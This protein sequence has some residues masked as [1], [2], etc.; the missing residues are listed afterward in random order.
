[1]ATWIKYLQQKIEDR[2]IEIFDRFCLS[3]NIYHEMHEIQKHNIDIQVQKR[4]AQQENCIKN[5]DIH[6]Q[7][8]SQNY[9]QNRTQYDLNDN[10]LHCAMKYSVL[11]GGKRIRPLFVIATGIDNIIDENAI[12]KNIIDENAM[13]EYHQ[14]NP[15]VDDLISLGCIFELIHSYS[16]IHDDLPAMD[17]DVLR[18]GKPSCHIQFDE[19]CAILA[20][21]ALQALAFELLS[22][23]N[24]IRHIDYKNR[25][26]I[27]NLLAKSCGLNGMAGGQAIDILLTNKT[28]QLDSLGLEQLSLM[29]NTMHQMKTGAL[30]S[31][32]ILSGFVLT[33]GDYQSEQ[34]ANLCL[35][36]KKIGLVF[37][38]IDDLLDCTENSASLGKTNGK[39]YLQ[40]KLTYVR[41]HGL[42]TTYNI[43]K[44]SINEIITELDCDKQ[45]MLI[46]LVNLIDIKNP[47]L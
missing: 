22:D 46:G 28:A 27:I 38:I 17:D 37:Q 25:L 11:D 35:L 34:Y 9:L 14:N 32:S 21:D 42:K 39:D 2:L 24:F 7:D 41:I 5:C 47:K 45:Y 18:R 31:A 12:N 44:Q 1:M 33:T 8:Q 10:R 26:Y 40:N 20:G 6:A 43:I 13:M 23:E 4:D 29:L 30:I 16:L 19:A 36:A 3:H 15:I